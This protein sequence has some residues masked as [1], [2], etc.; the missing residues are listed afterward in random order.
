MPGKYDGAVRL[1][2]EQPALLD[3]RDGGSRHAFADLERAR[4]LADIVDD[5][6]VEAEIVDEGRG[7]RRRADAADAAALLLEVVDHAEQAELRQHDVVAEGPQPRQHRLAARLAGEHFRAAVLHRSYPAPRGIDAN[8]SA[9]AR[10]WS[11]VEDF[12][13]MQL[14]EVCQAADRV[15]AQMLVIDRVVLQTIEQPD[16]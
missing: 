2:G 8:R 4:D 6:L 7:A 3:D 1:I 5:R 10:D 15:V 13:S 11:C 14:Q 16:E 9:V 12:E